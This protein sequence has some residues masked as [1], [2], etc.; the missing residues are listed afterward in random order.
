MT[1][2]AGMQPSPPMQAEGK[3]PGRCAEATRPACLR[4]RRQKAQT[5]TEPPVLKVWIV[6][7]G[8]LGVM[9]ELSRETTAF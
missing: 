5:G 7:L 3:T 6:T 1:S 8:P 4:P 2:A 9:F